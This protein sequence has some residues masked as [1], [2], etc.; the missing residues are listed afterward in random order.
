MYGVRGVGGIQDGAYGDWLRRC[1]LAA[2]LSQEQLAE[3]AGLSVRTISD[4]ERGHTSRPRSSSVSLI[5]GALGLRPA[6]VARAGA[7]R[8]MHDHGRMPGRARHHGLGHPLPVV[9]PAGGWPAAARMAAQV[10]DDAEQE[11]GPGGSRMLL[12]AITRE[13]TRAWG[14]AAVTG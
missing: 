6:A 2:G 8:A 7:G 5:A 10:I 4:I 3:R 12:A 13:L 9:Y 11:L 1:R 14:D